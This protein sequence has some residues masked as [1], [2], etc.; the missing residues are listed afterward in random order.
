MLALGY[1]NLYPKIITKAEGSDHQPFLERKIPAFL[2]IQEW[3][4]PKPYPYYHQAGDTFDHIDLPYTADVTRLNTA[5]AY[6]T[7]VLVQ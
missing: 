6:L 1:T 2:T 5:V 3:K 7:L 4:E